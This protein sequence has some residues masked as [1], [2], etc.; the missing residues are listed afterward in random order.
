MLFSFLA[1]WLSLPVHGAD[2]P[3]I[4]I[5]PGHTLEFP[6]SEGTCGTQ[7]VWVND[8]LS[9]ELGRQL[10]AQGYRVAFSRTPNLERKRIRPGDGREPASSLRA[11]ADRANNL[12]AAL[13]ISVHHDSV[14]DAALREDIQACPGQ[15]I[16][17]PLRISQEF[18][19]RHGVQA[20]FNIFVIH[21]SRRA[22]KLASAIGSNFVAAGEIPATFHNP[23]VE[24]DCTSC[25]WENRELGVMSRNLAV[26]RAPKM[27]AVLVEVT[28]L[29]VPSMEANANDPVYREKIAT[30]IRN[31]VDEYFKGN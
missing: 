23:K 5:D 14:A 28:N 20:G 2:R 17:K 16:N 27:P 6:G 10:S 3:L 8:Q 30:A 31:A 1:L 4:F 7:E 22:L 11:R 18:F 12:G 21:G 15:P 26:I 24:P 25:R 13:F 19:D 29:R 9:I